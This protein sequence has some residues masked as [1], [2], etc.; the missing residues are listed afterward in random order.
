MANVDYKVTVWNRFIVPEDHDE[1]LLEFLHLNP[2]ASMDDIN[3]WA[4]ERG[5]SGTHDAIIGTETDM[6]PEDNEGAATVEVMMHRDGSFVT[7]FDNGV[8]DMRPAAEQVVA[9][10]GDKPYAPGVYL[11]GGKELNELLVALGSTPRFEECDEKE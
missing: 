4:E 6:D 7:V 11:V 2:T 1:A 9:S 3:T 8:K 5:I 10:A